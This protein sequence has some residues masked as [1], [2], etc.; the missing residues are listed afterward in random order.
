MEPEEA[1]EFVTVEAAAEAELVLQLVL[2][3]LSRNFNILL[4]CLLQIS[5]FFWSAKNGWCLV[6]EVVSDTRMFGPEGEE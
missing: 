4:K 3:I 6:A 1:L 2:V 5:T